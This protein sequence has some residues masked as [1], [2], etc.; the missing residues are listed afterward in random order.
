ML[1]THSDTLILQ[2]PTASQRPGAVRPARRALSHVS[3]HAE[4]RGWR[5]FMNAISTITAWLPRRA[6]SLAFRT[7][8]VGEVGNA[9]S[10]NESASRS[11]KRAKEAAEVRE[12]ARRHMK[13]D[14]GFAADLLAAA[15]RHEILPS[16]NG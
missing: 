11:G 7:N 6:G 14:P 16:S 10:S 15:D 8:R 9:S 12:F 2:T 3:R 13:T 1:F 5:H 4:R